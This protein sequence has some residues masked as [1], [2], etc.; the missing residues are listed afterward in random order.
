MAT[1]DA[2]AAEAPARDYTSEP[3]QV[4]LTL[5]S[6]LLDTWPDPQ[7]PTTLA[8]RTGYSRDQC[9]RGLR[10]LALARHA[11]EVAAGWTIGPVL[12]TAAER[13]RQRTAALLATYLGRTS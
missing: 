2:P 11:E 6:A 4:V 3:Q 5:I 10:N 12:T 1:P 9:Y 8:A 7:T 13:I